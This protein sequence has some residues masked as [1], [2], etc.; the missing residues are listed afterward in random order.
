MLSRPNSMCKCVCLHMVTTGLQ[1]SLSHQNSTHRKRDG[2]REV[3]S[4]MWSVWVAKG[5]GSAQMREKNEVNVSVSLCARLTHT[6]G[7]ISAGDVAS[8]TGAHIATSSVG[9][10]SSIAHAGDGAAFVNIWNK[11][12][13]TSQKPSVHDIT[14]H[15]EYTSRQPTQIFHLSLTDFF[16]LTLV[17]FYL[18]FLICS[19]FICADLICCF[20]LYSPFL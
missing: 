16:F 9:A 13:V 7:A 14:G 4:Q 20:S 5:W 3:T 18:F 19:L 6:S 12:T 10:F 11:H 1:A 15:V 17:L 8:W 2:G